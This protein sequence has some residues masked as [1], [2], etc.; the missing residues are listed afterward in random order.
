MQILD[1]VLQH[2]GEPDWFMNQNV[3]S[4]E[5]L[6]HIF[7]MYEIWELA[8]RDYKKIKASKKLQPTKEECH[9]LLDIE[10]N[11][12]KYRL[13]KIGEASKGEDVHGKQIDLFPFEK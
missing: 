6:A 7:H 13:R 9:C 10:N 11:G 2:M 4:V 5:Q 12:I 8:R 1:E 3:T